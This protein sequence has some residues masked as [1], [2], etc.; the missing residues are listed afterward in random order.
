MVAP[1]AK[2]ETLVRE[3]LT[4]AATDDPFWHSRQRKE[5]EAS[6]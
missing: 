6:Y 1:P 4:V 5:L 3:G 2:P